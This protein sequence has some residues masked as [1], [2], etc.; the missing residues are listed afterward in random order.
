[1]GRWS[2]QGRTKVKDLGQEG[3]NKKYL[4]R[5]LRYYHVAISKKVKNKTGGLKSDKQL[6]VHYDHKLQVPVSLASN[7]NQ[8]KSLPNEQN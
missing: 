2:T 1:M 7:L 4:K 6:F 5:R 8:R 3:K